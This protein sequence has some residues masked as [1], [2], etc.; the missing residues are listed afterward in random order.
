M[1]WSH[2]MRLSSCDVVSQPG[3]V[4]AATLGATGSRRRPQSSRG[5]P[6]EDRIRDP[7]EHHGRNHRDVS[8]RLVSAAL[9][10][11]GEAIHLDEVI[12][13]AGRAALRP[14]GALGKADAQAQH[15]S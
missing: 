10:K 11:H 4:P 13:R 7:P 12:T 3:E 5:A 8:L 14:H 15:A 1:R 9:G 6:A 2:S